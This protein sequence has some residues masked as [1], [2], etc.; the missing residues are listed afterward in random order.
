MHN[1]LFIGV[2]VS[3]KTNQFCVMN[4]D[5]HVFFNS[6]Y[7]NTPEGSIQFVSKLKSIYEKFNFDKLIFCLESTGVYSFHIA[8]FLSSN[9]FLNSFNSEVYQ[10]NAKDIKN[11]KKSFTDLEKTDPTDAYVIA[12]FARVGRCKHLHPFRGSQFIALQRLTR[13]RF[14]IAKNLIKEKLYVMNN[15]YISFSGVVVADKEDKPFSDFFGATSSALLE[16]FTSIDVIA[17]TSLEDML[18][19]ISVKGKNRT[20]NP[21]NTVDLLNKA[22]RSSYRLD[23]TLYEPINIAIASSINLIKTYEVQIKQIDKAILSTV[24]GLDSNA[25]NVLLSIPG[26]GRVYAAGIL[27]E[28]GSINYFKHNDNLAKYVGLCWNRNQSGNFN[29]ENLSISSCANKYLRYYIIE[30]TS[31][32]IR[33]KFAFIKDFYN[34]KYKEVTKHQHKRALVLSARKFVRLIFGLLHKNQYYVPNVSNQNFEKC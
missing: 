1:S 34:I 33:C 10:V 14:H 22:V 23:E 19:F 12:D 21:N 5:Q 4:F 26:I 2:D 27:A 16:E 9:E 32:C 29:S 8:C 7:S 13:Q 25:Y 15:I 11:Y 6:K 31:S 18:N 24:C 17:N 20:K 28:I 3:L 30:G